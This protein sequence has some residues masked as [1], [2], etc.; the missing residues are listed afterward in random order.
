VQQGFDRVLDALRTK[1]NEHYQKNADIKRQLID[2]VLQLVDLQDNRQAVEEVKRLQAQWKLAGAALRKDEQVLWK[3]F[4]KG[5][6]A[7]FEKRQQQTK[8]YK[9]ELDVNKKAALALLHEVEGLM[10]LS[11]TVLLDARARVAECQA[12]YKALGSLPRAKENSLNR[13]FYKSVEQ[14][15]DKVARQLEASKEQVWLN[16]LTAADKIRLYQIAESAA[17]A[18]V[19]EQEARAYMS[20]GQQWPKNGLAALERKM[21]QGAGDATQEENEQAL[22]TF[23]IRAEIL[24]DRTTPDEDKPLR[25]QFQMSRLEQGLGQKMSDKNV[26]MNTMVF[27]W[28]AVGP[29]STVIYQPM[30]ERFLRCRRSF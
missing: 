28:V 12:E 4:R 17:T 15:S 25:M 10:E 16:F 6:D 30:L 26:E 13:D 11:G 19:L 18:A 27:D 8:E 9:A 5:C 24:C 22:R 7:I 20:S 2:Q 14:F 29:V 23:C 1:L 21:A 3:T